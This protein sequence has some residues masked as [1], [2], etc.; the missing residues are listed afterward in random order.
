MKKTFLL[1]F[2]MIATCNVFPQNENLKH[3]F[4]GA[5]IAT[6][7]NID[8]PTQNNLPVG[9]QM[10]E[11]VQMLEKLKTAGINAVLF[12][13]RTEC[14][15]LYASNYEPWSFWLTGEQGKT[16]DYLFDPLEFAISEAHSRGME[17]HAWFNPYRAV[18]NIGEYQIAPDHV[19]VKHPG[20][21]LTFGKYKMLDPGLPQVRKHVL[22]VM[23]DVL[24]RYDIDGIHFDDYFY[25]YGP[26]VSDE[27]SLTFSNH[28]RGF[29]NIDDWRRDNINLLMKEIYEVILSEKPHV[30]FG[31][32]PFGIVRNEYANTDGFNSYDIL[33]C[34]PLSWLEGKYVDYINPQLYWEIDHDKAPMR[35]LLPWWASV[36]GGRHLYIGQYSSRMAGQKYEGS[37]SE[38]GDQIKMI[39]NTPAAGGSVFFSAKSIANNWSSFADTLKST[40]YRYIALP[41]VMSWKDFVPPNKPKYLTITVNSSEVVLNWDEPPSASDGDYPAYYLVYRFKNGE[42]INLRDPSKIVYRT[43]PGETIFI[44]LLDKLDRGKYVY[45]VT[46]VDKLH[47]ENIDYE[48]RECLIE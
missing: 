31:I 37:K 38:L 26:K 5:W 23:R 35:K 43:Y 36:V 41:P 30:K 2:I 14:D 6:V 10:I 48:K 33:Y 4:R 44:D 47:N 34:D 29:T 1:L 21:I 22:N 16:P 19:S 25:P 28:N 8:W 40:Y 27:D 45:L 13:I 11:L 20:W 32:S 46:S 9:T 18:K 24:T 7:A 15:A 42:K 3:E 17:L 39:R 12:Q